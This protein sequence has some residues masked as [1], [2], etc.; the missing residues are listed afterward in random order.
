MG[1][2]MAVLVI[3]VWMDSRDDV[4]LNEQVVVH[5]TVCTACMQQCSHAA[6]WW[7][8]YGYLYVMML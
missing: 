2:D 5:Y 1:Q 3:V 8:K 7:A 6:R 4:D